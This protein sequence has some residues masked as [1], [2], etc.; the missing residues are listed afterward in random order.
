MVEDP[1]I[2]LGLGLAVVDAVLLGRFRQGLEVQHHGFGKADD[3]ADDGETQE[4]VLAADGGMG[5]LTEAD[6]A[7]L[8]TNGNG[9]VL[10]ALHHDAFQHRLSAHRAEAAIFYVVV[11]FLTHMLRYLR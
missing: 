8:A 6:G 3:A 7:V 9:I 1:F 5:V 4:L 2:E 11:C 10:L